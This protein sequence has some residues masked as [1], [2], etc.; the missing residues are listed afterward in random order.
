[1]SYRSILETGVMTPTIQTICQYLK[2]RWVIRIFFLSILIIVFHMQ[3]KSSTAANTDYD[4]L[5]YLV[6]DTFPDTFWHLKDSHPLPALKRLNDSGFAVLKRESAL[7]VACCRNVSEFLPM[8]RR[9]VERIVH[10]FGNYRILLGES[11]S[12]D[13]TLNFIQKWASE[14]ENVFVESH[15]NLT[16]RIPSSRTQRIAFCRN[17][18][19]NITRQESWLLN[20]RYL[21]VMDVDINANEV[22]TTQNFLS[23][24]EY[25]T[26]Y[27]AAMTASQ[28]QTYY[29]IWALRAVGINYDCWATVNHYK[30][31]D[32][33]EKIY[34]TV[35][36]RPIPRS[37][38][39]LHVYS[40][41]GGFGVYQTKYLNGCWYQGSDELGRD[42][43]EHVA[44]HHCIRKNGGSIFINSR[45]QNSDGTVH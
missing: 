34:V 12:S 7:V 14:S 40:A 8:F 24:F 4:D 22:L 15:G 26:N 45:F 25:D 30:H 23:N 31:L 16:R 18:L 10:L 42:S 44:F 35:H 19:L 37:F 17:H 20:S 11:D 41:F 3:R 27:W 29:D 1:M 36:T 28:A 13:G 33:A 2:Y 6:N 9:N 5:L 38:G 21:L 39:L 32:I 43:C